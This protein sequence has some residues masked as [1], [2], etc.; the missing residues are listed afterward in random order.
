MKW[1]YLKFCLAIALSFGATIVHADELASQKAYVEKWQSDEIRITENFSKAKEASNEVCY[2]SRNTAPIFNYDAT[3]VGFALGGDGIGKQPILFKECLSKKAFAINFLS[4]RNIPRATEDTLLGLPRLNPAD[5]KNIGAVSILTDILADKALDIYK[6]V[7]TSIIKVAYTKFEST[8]IPY[9]WAS[10]LNNN[11]DMAIVPDP[12]L[13]DVYIKNGV[14]IPIFVLPLPL[15]LADFLKIKEKDRP[16]RPFVFGFSGGFWGRKNHAKILDA[17]AQEF[18]NR[19]DVQLRLHGRF[20]EEQI[21]QNLINKIKEYN[22][23]NVELITSPL[24]HFDYLNFF[25]SLDCYVSLSMGEGFAATPREALAASIP[26][27]L[28]DNTSQTLICNSGAARV[29]PSKITVPALYDCHL[30]KEIMPTENSRFIRNFTP[31]NN[32]F[33]ARNIT[34]GQIDAQIGYQVDCTIEDARAA[35]LDVYNDYAQYKK[36]ARDG[37][38]WVKRYLHENLS[39]KYSCLVKPSRIVMGE[40]NIIGDSFI[41]TNSKELFAKYKFLLG[42]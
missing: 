20:G 39:K 30:G 42:H 16:N 11:F 15:E 26:C 25:K 9:N 22:L 14:T 35:M 5:T 38:N 23:T 17:F 36:R 27:I 19:S 31:R 32:Y 2:Y 4:T 41:M 7:P 1:Y 12:F 24:D 13:V 29:V 6:Q 34:T 28:T 21:I 3:L 40:S 10:I 33:L 37:K 8:E 18:G